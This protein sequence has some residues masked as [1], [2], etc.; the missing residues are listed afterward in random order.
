M[1]LRLKTT[2]LILL[3][4]LIA[5][6][7]VDRITLYLWQFE[8][9]RLFHLLQ[10]SAAS[11]QAKPPKTPYGYLSIGLEPL[12]VMPKSDQWGTRYV[13]LQ[14]DV[15]LAK[16]NTITID[17]GGGLHLRF[18]PPPLAWTTRIVPWSNPGEHAD[19]VDDDPRL[20]YQY[21]ITIEPFGINDV[22]VAL[23]RGPSHFADSLKAKDQRVLLFP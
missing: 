14:T 10:A 13:T 23:T 21:K 7:A 18:L 4:T 3:A 20:H 6:L 9:I 15:P 11:G 8:V 22:T 5:A 2:R 17:G 16:P 19:P 12:L 1:R